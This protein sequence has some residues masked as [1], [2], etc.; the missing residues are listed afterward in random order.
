M[1][2]SDLHYADGSEETLSRDEVRVSGRLLLA[3][4]APS[5]VLS[6]YQRQDPDLSHSSSLTSLSLWPL[7]QCKFGCLSN[8]ILLAQHVVSAD[9]AVHCNQGHSPQQKP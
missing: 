9:K 5:Y 1:R 6:K 8:K 3:K 7:H 2:G 4:K